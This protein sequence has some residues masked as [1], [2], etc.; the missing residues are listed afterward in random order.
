[1]KYHFQLTYSV[2]PSGDSDKEER[3]AQ[4]ARK[5]LKNIDGWFSL[6][7]VE[8]TIVG[9]L[10]LNSVGVRDKREEAKE[11][12]E[13]RIADILKNYEI[14]SDVWVNASLMVDTLGEH[15]EFRI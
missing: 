15:I 3:A 1:M 5:L 11:K 12:V 13:E 8:T 4:K 2:R 6:E 14:F 9:T 7:S 10:K